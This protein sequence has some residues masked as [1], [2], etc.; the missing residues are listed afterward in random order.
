MQPSDSTVEPPPIRFFPLLY[1]LAISFVSSLA[2]GFARGDGASPVGAV[3]TALGLWG[4]V[5]VIV[6]VGTS[7]AGV[8]LGWREAAQLVSWAATPLL[9]RAA[10]ALIV[11][12]AT[13]LPP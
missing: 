12:M 2:C 8:P 9:L 11:S 10:A 13:G 6:A 1:L 4:L 5:V 7:L 3:L